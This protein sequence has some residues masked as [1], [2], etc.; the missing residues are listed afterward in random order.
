MWTY[1]PF[2]YTKYDNLNMRNK[3]TK[4]P[5]AKLTKGTEGLLGPFRSLLQIY[6]LFYK[7]NL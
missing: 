7:L 6:V 5:P 1:Y 3:G 4:N 2:M